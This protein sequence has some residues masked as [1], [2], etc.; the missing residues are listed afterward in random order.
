MDDLDNNLSDG[1]G[2]DFDAMQALLNRWE[3]K[4]PKPSASETPDPEEDANDADDEHETAGDEGDNEDEANDGDGQDQEDPQEAEGDEDQDKEKPEAQR[5]Y[6]DDDSYFKVKVDGAELEVSAK[7]LTRLYGQ[8]ASLTRK[9]QEVAQQNKVVTE[10]RSQYETALNAMYQKAVERAKPY[11][12]IDL[13]LAAKN[14]SSE[15]YMALKADA[16]AASNEVKFFEE[17][18]KGHQGR[19]SKE[20]QEAHAKAAEEA[21]AQLTTKDSPSYIDGWSDDVYNGLVDYG[22]KMGIPREQMLNSTSAPSFKILWMAQQFEKGKA[23]ATKKATKVVGKKPMNAK[24]P[25]TRDGDRPAHAMNRLKKSGSVD[26]AAM[27]LF[28]RW[29]VSD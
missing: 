13:A 2:D 23:V 1:A 14:L 3:K 15:D 12:Q 25:K 21:I 6:A 22:V 19:V 20:A 27:T 16:E 9:S 8:E 18:L 7:D 10:R 29:G 11:K 24:G 5:K 26:D 17:E 28:E 4:D